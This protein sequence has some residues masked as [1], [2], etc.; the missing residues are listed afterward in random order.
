MGTKWMI[1]RIGTGRWLSSDTAWRTSAE[2]AWTHDPHTAMQ[3]DTRE[4]AVEK[5]TQ[6]L[7][8]VHDAWRDIQPTEH[9][10][11]SPISTPANSN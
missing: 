5:I 10:F 11:M 1:E 9:I 6:I 4:Q 2:G 3:F 8:Y 7:P